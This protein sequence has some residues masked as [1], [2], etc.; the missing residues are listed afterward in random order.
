MHSLYIMKCFACIVASL[1][2]T[3]LVAYLYCWSSESSICQCSNNQCDSSLPCR[4]VTSNFIDN[5]I[6]YVS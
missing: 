2:L 4:N 1:E 3:V 5:F 6:K